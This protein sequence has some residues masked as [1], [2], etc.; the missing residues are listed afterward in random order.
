MRPIHAVA[1]GAFLAALAVW[2]CGSG[3]ESGASRTGEAA[4]DVGPDAGTASPTGSSDGTSV[5]P[6]RSGALAFAVSPV[7]CNASGRSASLAALAIY[8][9]DRLLGEG[10]AGLSACAQ[11]KDA[12]SIEIGIVNY[13]FSSSAPGVG[14]G[15]YSV[16][17]GPGAQDGCFASAKY[18]T[19]DATCG[20]T[21]TSAVGGTVTIDGVSG[22]TVSGSYDLTFQGRPPVKGSF[23][24]SDC[25]S[26][27]A[28][29]DCP[30]SGSF[31]WPTCQGSV[32]CQ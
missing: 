5:L 14:P 11:A 28:I 30:D 9:S 15:T 4:A 26:Q 1:C 20:Y 8:V 17:T 27:V 21:A 32:T 22:G 6:A 13:A 23:L 31:P 7:Q 29:R 18:A 10:C 2:G 19:S 3:G 12:T 24:A 25:S 16:G